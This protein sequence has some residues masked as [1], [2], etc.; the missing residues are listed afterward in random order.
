[1]SVVANDTVTGLRRT[2]AELRQQLGDC[3]AELNEAVKQQSATADVL[4]V[5]NQSRGDLTP[6]FEAVLD[7]ALGLCGAAFGILRTYDGARLHMAAFRGAPPAYAE[8]LRRAPPSV[9]LGPDNALVR[10][11]RGEP[12]VHIADAAE[13]RAYLSGDPLRRAVVDLGRARTLLGVPL[14]KNNAL[15]GA[16]VIYR[17]EVRLFS[18][19][20]IALLQNFAAQAAI[21]ME[22]ARLLT[23]QREA[24]EQLTAIAEI[25]QVINAS[26]GKLEPVFEAMVDKALGLC[27]A[28]FGSLWTY[29]GKG[30]NAVA[31]RGVPPFFAE[32][33]TRA[34][35][36]VGSDSAHGRLLRGEP[37]VHITDVTKEKAYQS[38]DPIR[39]A[40]VELGGGRTLLAVPLRKDA[41]FLGDFVIYRTEVRPF[42]DKQIALME[43]FAAQ[44]VIAMDNA[45]LLGELRARNDELAETLEF[46]TATGE[47]LRSV[48]SSPDNLQSVFEA[49]LEKATELCKAK[50]GILFLYDGEAFTVAADR[51]LPPAY[52][53]AVRGQSFSAEMNT[54]ICRA[55]ESKAPVHIRDMAEDAAYAKGEPLRTAAFELGGVRSFVGVPLLKAGDLIGAFAIYRDEPGGFAE[56]QIGLVTTFADQAVIAIENTRLL[57]ELRQ[58]LQ[59]QTATADVLK[60]ISRST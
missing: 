52:A 9:G 55:I 43:N 25:L 57:N 26:P 21:A 41:R 4:Q 39:R 3:R 18:D 59:Q 50:F 19:K 24:L 47:V 29:D 42:S 60:I 37:V 31:L 7:K 20:Q 36:P 10:L 33:L 49:M 34:P 58:S 1:M 38:G 28:A 11:L 15:L 13:D 6:V 23:E 45:G 8:H 16:F 14:R 17:Q 46:Q 54:A 40:L 53:K 30:M 48:A 2:I 51:N 5:I 44:A 27:G 35:H 32:F 22:N 56:K 12:V